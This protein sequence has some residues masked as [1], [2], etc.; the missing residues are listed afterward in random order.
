[1]EK[2]TY[3]NLIFLLVILFPLNLFS[4]QDGPR[5]EYPD[6]IINPYWEFYSENRLSTI[7]GGKGYTGVASLGDMSSISLNPASLY[8]EKR[9]N[10][11]V[12]YNFRTRVNYLPYFS[13]DDYLKNALPS[14]SVGG[15][16]RINENF[17]TGFSYQ[18]N[19]SY[20]YDFILITTN[21]FGT[22]IG[23]NEAYYK[24]ISHSFIVPF[25]F[26]YEWLRL[27]ANLNLTYITGDFDYG[28]DIFINEFPTSGKAE[29]WSF[30]PQI[31]FIISPNKYFSLGASYTFGFSDNFEWEYNRGTPQTSYCEIPSRLSVGTEGKLL[32]DK[33]RLSLEY[34]YANTSAINYLKDKSNI[35]L[36]AEYSIN[37]F[38]IVRGG[39][40]TLF[41][42]RDVDDTWNYNTTFDQFFITVGGT[43]KYK[44]LAFNVALLSSYLTSSSGV[45]HSIINAGIGFDF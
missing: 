29:L 28:E 33:L 45:K 35:H 23:R 4:Q 36:G 37:D 15:G 39:F 21:E 1:M 30:I 18:N 12:S 22:E 24:F 7:S 9:F 13:S 20:K 11:N 31:G 14:L 43:Y 27:G 17:Q 2:K 40:F 5:G 16:Y 42:F 3:L 25:V 19:Y 26:N 44:G 8:I 38:W 10:T 34:H 41:D 32:E 6:A